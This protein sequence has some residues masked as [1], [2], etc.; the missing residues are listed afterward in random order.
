ME[1]TVP[2]LAGIHALVEGL[3]ET[4]HIRG[5]SFRD[6]TEGGELTI[7]NHRPTVMDSGLSLRPDPGMTDA[8][9]RD[10]TLRRPNMDRRDFLT[11]AAAI[12]PV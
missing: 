8:S 4:D 1:Y 2:V 3:G 12:A 6:A 9:V 7:H 11:G 10:S 5:R